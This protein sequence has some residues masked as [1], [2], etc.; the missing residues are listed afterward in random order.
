MHVMTCTPCAD[1]YIKARALLPTGHIQ[2]SVLQKI[3]LDL[4]IHLHPKD[5]HE[6]EF[7]ARGDGLSEFSIKLNP[8]MPDVVNQLSHFWFA[9][10]RISYPVI[11]VSG[12]KNSH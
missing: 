7:L 6:Y 3:L 8:Y 2:L 9:L 5:V 12:L 4:K 10:C 11:D 1:G